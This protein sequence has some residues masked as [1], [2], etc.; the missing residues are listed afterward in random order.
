MLLLFYS[1]ILPISL[2][3]QIFNSIVPS[4]L[5]NEVALKKHV[6]L[7]DS[8]ALRPI[9][10]YTRSVNKLDS[11]D[12]FEFLTK[13][14]LP[15]DRIHL[16]SGFGKRTHPIT[17]ELNKFHSGIDLDANTDMVYC[18]LHGNVNETGYN[19]I[20]GNFVRIVHGNYTSIYGHLAVI[21][22]KSGD[23]VVPGSFIGVSGSTGR[24]TGEHLHFSVKY[25]GQFLNPLTFLYQMM[26]QD[27]KNFYSSLNNE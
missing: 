16:T 13:P 20:I 18:I 25:K 11:I 21:L 12:H 22:V 17:G 9:S 26:K 6:S 8:I 27:V 3:G 10:E 23:L 14:R 5:N 7:L 19:N 24:V 2:Y 1:V 15:L 4:G